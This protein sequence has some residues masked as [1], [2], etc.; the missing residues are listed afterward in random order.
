ML[1]DYIS[2]T[3]R[4]CPIHTSR[5]PITSRLAVIQYLMSCGGIAPHLV[6]GDAKEVETIGIART[7][8][9]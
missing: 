5:K 2:A 3:D 8:D 6:E 4:K 7:T 9:P 1:A